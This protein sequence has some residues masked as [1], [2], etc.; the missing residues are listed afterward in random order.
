M[1][2]PVKQSGTLDNLSQFAIEFDGLVPSEEGWLICLR[3]STC[4]HQWTAARTSPE[5]EKEATECPQALT[6]KKHTG[7]SP[8]KKE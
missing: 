1:D 8:K 5:F 6:A 4:G 3:C 2:R 7:K